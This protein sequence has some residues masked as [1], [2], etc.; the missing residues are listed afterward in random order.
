M[1]RITRTKPAR[2]DLRDI[3]LR[4]AQ[5][6]VSAADRMLERMERTVL[7]LAENRELD[8]RQDR[9]RPGLRR[10]VLGSYLIFYQPTREGIRVIRILHGARRWENLL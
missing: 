3:W 5:D 8:E 1:A 4:I 7:M 6:D 2:Q 9:H 10:F